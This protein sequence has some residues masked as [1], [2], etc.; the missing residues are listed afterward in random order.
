MKL[1]EVSYFGIFVSFVLLFIGINYNILTGNVGF[2]LYNIS[3][4]LG[5]FFL[6]TLSIILRFHIDDN[7]LS[8]KPQPVVPNIQKTI[9]DE[10]LPQEN[11]T[12][13]IENKQ[14]LTNLKS[15]TSS[16][17]MLQSLD[18][19]DHSWKQLQNLCRQDATLSNEL[20]DKLTHKEKLE[21]ILDLYSNSKICYEKRVVETDNKNIVFAP[22]SLKEYNEQPEVATWVKVKKKGQTEE[23]HI[24]K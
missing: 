16:K 2:N 10:K 23:T 4:A 9:S 19:Y 13:D 11:I 22:V 15:H 5:G 21:R 1:K 20:I 6:M 12:S 18:K 8:L 3:F 14:K 17:I 7:R 24:I